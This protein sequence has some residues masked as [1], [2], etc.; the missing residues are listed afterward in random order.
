MNL[1]KDAVK[2][3]YKSKVLLGIFFATIVFSIVF[4]L[5]YYGQKDIGMVV[6]QLQQGLKLSQYL[7][8]TLLFVSYE[9]LKNYRNDGMEEIAKAS[10]KGKNR[11]HIMAA[12]LILNIW[13]VI[14]SVVICV[15]VLIA[16]SFYGIKEP[17]QKYLIHIIKNILVNISLIL[18]LGILIGIFLSK[19][20]NRIATYTVMIVIAYMVSPYPERIADQ[21]SMSTQ[22]KTPIYK[23][24]EMFNIM[25]LVSTNYTPN[26]AFGESLLPYRIALIMFWIF[27]VGTLI[28]FTEFNKS[29]A[30]AGIILTGVCACIYCMPSSKVIMDSNSDNTLAHDQY[31]YLVQKHEVKEESADYKISSYK[32]NI[33]IGL[34]MRVDLTM[35]VDKTLS[36]YKMTLYHGYKVKNAYNDK[37]TKLKVEQNGDYITI[38]NQKNEETNQIHLIYEGYSSAY[39]ANSQ[40]IFLPGYF[41][42]YPRAG[43]VAVFDEETWDISNSFVDS[44]TNFE[45]KVNTKQNLY[46]NLKKKGEW[47]IGK[48]DGA[49]ILSGFYAEKKL[50]NGNR[51]IYPYLYGIGVIDKEQSI[52]KA[53]NDYYSIIEN[54]LN[55]MERKNTTVF[56]VPNVN[57]L[58]NQRDGMYQIITRSMSI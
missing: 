34:Q 6:A 9:Y 7:F 52:D 21:I 19:F 5:Q 41:A 53:M 15:C 23:I 44:E 48:C 40:G 35:D 47:Y 37:N 46:T 56:C 30:I 14:L 36:K 24:V 57:Q 29:K 28:V 27:L 2:V 12:Y 49:T 17:H 13:I 31:Y 42:Y 33:K 3:F 1:I 18:E 51:I 39:Y 16:F 45:I 58:V 38:I 22:G 26:Y 55:E 54:G 50:S 8:I 25:P 32:M 43:F 20:K 10:K 4:S 11:K